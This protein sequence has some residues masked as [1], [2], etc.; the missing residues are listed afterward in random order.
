MDR[1]AA[2]LRT[3]PDDVPRL[4]GRV[5]GT[6]WLIAGVSIAALPAF[7]QVTADFWPW[8]AIWAAGAFIW[9]LSAIF[10][11]DWRRAP[12]WLM[13][14]STVLAPVVVALITQATGGTTSPARMFVF[15]AL[16]FATC[17]L[18]VPWAIAV[19]A[20]CSL[21]WVVPTA[22]E[23]GVVPALAEL[24]IAAPMFFVIGAVILNGRRLMVA[25]HDSA[26]R[27]SDEH[28]ALRSI[29]TAV[30][31][32][33]PPE[34]VCD[35]A[36]E[37]AARLL[38]A[39]G[40]QILRY[41]HDTG[42]MTL[43]GFWRR[44]GRP[45]RKGVRIPVIP[46]TCIA[47]LW[48]TETPQRLDDVFAAD[49]PY[50]KALAARGYHA[51]VG[52]PVHVR[53]KL[54][55]GLMAS[56]HTANALP[57]DAA[58]HL[59]EFAELIG[60]AVA[61]T[62]KVERLSSDAATD[63]LTGLA[64]HREFQERLRAELAR[65][66]RYG[67]AVA[68]ALIDVDNFKVVNDT[69]GHAIGDDVLCAVAAH[70][71][72]HLRTEDLLAR[73]GGDEFAVLLPES[74]AASAAVALERAR[75]AIE[76][77]SFAGGAQVTI[78]AGVCDIAHAEDAESLLR[79]ADGALYWSKDHGR[80][81]VSTYD[82]EVVRE[83]SPAERIGALERSQA[84]S[85]IR[86]LARAID[87]RDQSTREHSERVA[88]LVARMAEQRGWA[89]ERIALLHEAA[90]VHDVGKIGMPDAIL[91]KPGPLTGAEYEVITTHAELGARM[92]GESLSPEQTEWILAHHERPDGT[93]YPR[94]LRAAQISEGVGLLTVA[95]A[96]DVMITGRPYAPG[97]PV[98][99]A[100]A[101][102]RDLVGQQFTAE[103][104]EALEAVHAAASEPLLAT[105]S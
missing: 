53:G 101:E 72:E 16:I 100:L 67:R 41:N 92:V 82:P 30:A 75:G 4:A 80:N 9:G 86:A 60:M 37:H 87:A 39:D 69:G 44:A 91:F 7:P 105:R 68:V 46:D 52:T 22:D 11:I 65:R 79:F 71:R 63:P 78:S 26:A 35:L 58:E 93:G 102:C 36:A 64:N 99:D 49:D 48:E 97:R 29:A 27:L 45:H 57:E 19:L 55:G 84:L 15:L 33:E 1:L 10:L 24:T 66:D 81:R 59:A 50:A 14:S 18:T 47:R 38:G 88:A 89:V 90:L 6:C 17:F 43:V 85:G 56:S 54:W 34:R 51:W 12:R 42:D 3:S 2:Q 73:V 32:G 40:G 31:A 13:P 98:E 20:A 25:M 77:S 62:E 28:H 83:L 95:D 94:G 21:A 74:D 5:G 76:R 61:N 96:F 8:P 103:A 104:V 70:L 23:A